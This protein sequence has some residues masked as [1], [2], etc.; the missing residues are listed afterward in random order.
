M[1]DSMADNQAVA[2]AKIKAASWAGAPI[3]F[4]A[5]ADAYHAVGLA[6]AAIDPTEDDKRRSTAAA[7]HATALRRLRE[8]G[9]IL[10][11]CLHEALAND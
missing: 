7:R 2:A 4:S 6:L 3:Q 5:V 1:E 8:A 10:S 11:D 9:S